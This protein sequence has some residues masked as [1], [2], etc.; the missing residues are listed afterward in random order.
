MFL[1]QI[2]QVKPWFIS[3][4]LK[5]PMAK[6]N[7]GLTSNHSSYQLFLVKNGGNYR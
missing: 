6:I 2:F 1:R 5:A 4:N 7:N 3:P